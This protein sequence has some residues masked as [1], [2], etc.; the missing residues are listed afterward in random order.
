MGGRGRWDGPLWRAGLKGGMETTAI[1]ILGAA[2]W[3]GGPSPTLLRRT[4]QGAALWRAG[5]GA[6]VIP[7][8]GLGRHP[9]AEAM[10]MRDILIAEGVPA[11]AI[12]PEAASTSTAENIAL[13]LPI[14]RRLGCTRVVIVTDRYHAPRA[15][16]IARRAGLSAVTSAPPLNG[17]RVWPQIKGALREIPA[18]LAAVLRLR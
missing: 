10:V 9:P 8:G 7:C 16:L 17:A 2:V 5:V 18:L 14:L 1:L 11:A 6:H 4:R 13:A 3:P 12:H 15:R